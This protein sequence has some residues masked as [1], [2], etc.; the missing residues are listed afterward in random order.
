[1][2]NLYFQSYYEL[3]LLF[4]FALILFMI[5]CVYF[6]EM[7]CNYKTQKVNAI[8]GEVVLLLYITSMTLLPMIVLSNKRYG[9]VSLSF[10]DQSLLICGF[11]TI[12]YYMTNFQIKKKEN[13]LVIIGIL[14]TFAD[15][16]PNIDYSI[17]YILSIIVLIIRSFILS[18]KFYYMKISELSAFSI[19]E[20][21][22]TLPAGVMFC[23][24]NGYIYLINKKMH[25]LIWRFTNQDCKN[26]K[27][28]WEMLE[29]GTLIEDECQI[30]EGDVVIRSTLDAWRFSKRIFR[31]KNTTYFE[32]IAI[33]ATE[34]IGAFYKLEEESEKL[35]LQTEEIRTLNR[36]M[37][38]LRR[39]KEYSRIRSQVHDVLGQRLTAMQRMSQSGNIANY[40]DFLELLQDTI[41][42]IKEKR[43]G[44]SK[45]LFAEIYYYFKR[46]GLSIELVDELP[47]EEEITFMFLAV[48]REA[49]TNAIRHAGATIVFVR[50]YKSIE[51]YRIEITDNGEKPKKGLIEGGGLFGIRNRIENAGGTLK[52][53]VIPE[54]SLIITIGRGKRDDKSISS[55]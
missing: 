42:Q 33:D 38:K 31:E 46:I 3:V 32:I 49:C 50:I 18:M 55:R 25:E 43:G 11:V 37:E 15:I 6:G 28:F 40:N 47:E 39:E 51:K 54:F 4:S 9:I 48:L 30:V 34:S 5:E 29:Q 12:V 16:I 22:D 14:L 8:M 52:V 27:L 10:L 19:K 45:D 13:I 41:K 23:D 44:D 17:L 20:G 21:L 2:N 53:E 24:M 26:G 36:N 7:I 35:M 1:M